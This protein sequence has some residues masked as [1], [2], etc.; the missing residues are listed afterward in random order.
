MT[1][2][3]T[4]SLTTNRYLGSTDVSKALSVRRTR[5]T[6]LRDDRGDVLVW[7]DVERRILRFNA[8]GRD[9]LGTKGRYFLATALSEGKV[10][11]GRHRGADGAG[12]GGAVK[13]KVVLSGR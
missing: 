4:R 3:R 6:I 1:A 10:D 12:R 13:R 7:R 11:P 2:A 5:H 8:R 9:G